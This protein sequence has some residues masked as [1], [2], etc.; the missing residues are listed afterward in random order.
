MAHEPTDAELFNLLD[1]AVN[2]DAIYVFQGV[3]FHHA[4]HING[5]C[6]V[7]N[8]TFLEPL[9]IG[10]GG[11]IRFEG[12]NKLTSKNGRTYVLKDGASYV[13]EMVNDVT[14]CVNP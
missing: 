5:P 9:T 7:R 13:N 14:V 2:P 11:S 1:I 10:F 12:V 3:T 4:I 6:I 8:C